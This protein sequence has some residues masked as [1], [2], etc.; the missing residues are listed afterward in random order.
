MRLAD[1]VVAA[2][3]AVVAVAVATACV[4]AAAAVGRRA[5]AT[6]C[7]APL[8]AAS[9]HLQRHVKNLIPHRSLPGVHPLSLSVA[10]TAKS[11][12]SKKAAVYT[13]RA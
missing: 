9:P 8:R 10:P 11:I 12:E 1:A 6:E 13:S 4:D 5:L 7:V 3:A 2:A